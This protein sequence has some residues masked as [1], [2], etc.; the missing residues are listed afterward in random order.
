MRRDTRLSVPVSVLTITTTTTTTTRPQDTVPVPV[1]VLSLPVS[2]SVYIINRERTLKKTRNETRDC[3]SLSLSLS[4]L[5]LW[6]YCPCPGFSVY[7]I[8]VRE[9]TR[10]DCQTTRHTVPDNV[11]VLSLPVSLSVYYKSREK[12][13]RDET[14]DCLSCPCLDLCPV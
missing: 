11:S 3:L 10:D 7:I 12:E 13:T 5:N 14:R 6:S 8:T 1:S 2:L 9:K 4:C